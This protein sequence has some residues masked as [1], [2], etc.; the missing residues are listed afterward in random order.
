[1]RRV[2]LIH[3]NAAEARQ[4]AARLRA[5]G[6]DVAWGALNATSL[7]ELKKNPPTAVVIDLARLPM[8]G[9]DAAVAIRHYNSTRHVPVVFVDGDTEKVARVKE[10]LPDAVY[11]T[12]GRIRSSLRRAV[13]HP[14][15]APVVHRS[16]LAGYSGTPL[17][18]KLGITARSVVALV[19]APRGFDRTLGS[20]PEGVTL[21]RQAHRRCDLIIWFTKTRRELEGRVGRLGALAGRGG[22]WIVWPKKVSGVVSDLSQGAVRRVGLAAGLVDYKVCAIDATWAGLRFS[23]RKSK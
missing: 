2:R 10:L 11:T 6:Y 5:A 14:P 13:A 18:R 20:L 3:W 7:R 8:Q 19:G 21:S 22:L 9:R 17:V 1:M 15:K 4:R 12:W 16:L 23:R